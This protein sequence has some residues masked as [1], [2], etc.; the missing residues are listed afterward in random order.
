MTGARPA[1]WMKRSYPSLK[2]LASYVDDLLAR[3]AFF[4]S[5]STTACAEG[6]LAVGLLLHAGVPHGRRCR[7]TR[8]S[9][10]SRSTRSSSSSRCSTPR[11]ADEPPPEDGVHVHGL[12]L[13]GARASPTTRS[14][15]PS[16]SRRC[17]SRAADDVAPPDPRGRRRAAHYNC[18]LYKTSDR[19]GTLS[20]TGHS[21]NFVMYLNL[22]SDRPA[23]H[24][25]GRGVAGAL[26]AGRVRRENRLN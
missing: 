8:A 24:W 1:L 11:R 22:P 26:P 17:S 5:G 23:D 13:E 15:S 18:P 25:I 16:R 6:L 10:R 19:R 12:F 9:T 21:T 2:P 4:R 20:T 7:T 14:R 3:L